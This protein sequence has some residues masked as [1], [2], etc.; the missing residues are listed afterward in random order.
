[1]MKPPPSEGL[2]RRRLLQGSAGAVL[3]GIVAG[4]ARA[5]SSP[6][7]VELFTSQGCSSCPP[8]EAYLAEL[9]REPGILALAYHV[10]YWDD[11][12]WHDPF[13]SP[14]A[15]A[16]QRDYARLMALSSV[17]TPQMVINGRFETVGSERDDVAAAIAKA[18][19]TASA[20]A[21]ALTAAEDTLTATIAAGP[22]EGR[23]WGALYD[24]R[25]ETEV[26]RGE[27]AGRRL[28]NVN[29]VR[30]IEAL[31]AWSGAA[32]TIPHAP[33]QLGAGVAVFVQSSDG[34]ILG[35]AAFNN[36][37]A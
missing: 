9:A 29:V 20:A 12:G 19:A 6:V 11:L 16:R 2:S 26:Q 13:S 18:A 28:V 8:A 23:V 34:A 10:D 31:G 5:A 4:R 27:N 30:S 17:Y 22:G 3:A 35:A 14:A 36:A 24:L 15:T 21:I 37:S 1:M 33:P 7:L 25:H 32:L